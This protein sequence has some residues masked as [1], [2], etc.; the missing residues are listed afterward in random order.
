M[1]MRIGNMHVGTLIPHFKKGDFDKLLVPLPD[2]D[3]QKAIG[4]NYLLLSQKIELNRR[5]N[6]TL[7]A[8]ARALFQ[9]WFVDFDPVRAKAAG[10][11]PAGM[12]PATAA[13]F[14]S[15]FEDSALGEIPK[16]WTVR[17]LDKIA[18]FLN[19]LALQKYPAIDGQ[20]TM[21]RLKIAELRQGSTKGAES[22]NIN[23]PD[24]F[25]VQDG[26]VV[27]SWS[28]SL[29]VRL[30][31]G[32]KAALNQHL[33]KV[34]SD[35]FERWFYYLWTQHHLDDFQA[36]AASKAT[37][38]GHIK[39]H[40]L[41]DAKVVVPSQRVLEAADCLISPLLERLVR[42]DLEARTLCSLRDELLPRLLA[43]EISI[44]DV[45]PKVQG[46]EA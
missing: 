12:D 15:E 27:F 36:T 42:N 40:H 30:W 14:P 2:D 28:G 8:M 22:S 39:R 3:V 11:T 32:G 35:E 9:S 33:F 24:Q 43:G 17:S 20:P 16:G 38:M 45:T 1:Q 44:E 4:D 46:G 19:G 13:L 10:Q 31:T 23:V 37:T 41:S 21:P 26:D 29:L 7:E 18:D 5:M 34:T 25:V 6:A